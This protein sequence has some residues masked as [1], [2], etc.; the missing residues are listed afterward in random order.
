[1]DFLIDNLVWIG[2]ALGSGAMLL[3][4]LLSRGGG[5]DLSPQQAVLLINRENPVIVDVREESEFASGHIAAA[6]NIP[7]SRFKER[8][9]ELAKYKQK[10]LLVNCLSGSRTVGACA[11][12]KSAGFEKV[13]VLKGGVNA[14]RQAN[15]PLVKD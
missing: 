7:L 5:Q 2:L 9:G 6:K 8:L 11:A 1:M 15:L 13:Y 4:P 12:L 14:W 3:W 10:P